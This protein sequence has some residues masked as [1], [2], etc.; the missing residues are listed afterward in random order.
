MSSNG[1]FVLQLES[2]KDVHFASSVF[3]RICEIAGIVAWGKSDQ[4]LWVE[5]YVLDSVDHFQIGDVVDEDAVLQT[6]HQTLAI[7]L[8]RQNGVHVR[9]L[10]NS[11]I[12]FEM[13]RLKLPWRR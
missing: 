8:H 7:E 10:K 5:R 3:G 13:P 12:L 9:M 4:S 6:H 1:Q 2:V 11:C